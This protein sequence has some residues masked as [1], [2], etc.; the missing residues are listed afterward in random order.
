MKQLFSKKDY[1]PNNGNSRKKMTAAKRL[2]RN[3]RYKKRL[4]SVGTSRKSN[5]NKSKWRRR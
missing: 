4:K 5:S 3:R 2:M 1:K